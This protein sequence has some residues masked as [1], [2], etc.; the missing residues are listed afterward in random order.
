MANSGAKEIDCVSRLHIRKVV[1]RQLN[2]AV[3]GRMGVEYVGIKSDVSRVIRDV[4]LQL[5]SLDYLISNLEL[6]HFNCGQ[7]LRILQRASPG[8]VYFQHA[9]KRQVSCLQCFQLIK[10]DTGRM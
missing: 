7:Q 9:L 1:T 2:G 6:R 5:Q 3:T 10:P 4:G 8:C